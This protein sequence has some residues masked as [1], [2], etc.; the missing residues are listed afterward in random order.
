MAAPSELEALIQR[1]AAFFDRT[2]W[3]SFGVTTL[4]ALILYLVT[5][6]PDVTLG[7]AGIFCVGG[8]YAGVAH[9]P[10]YPLST[11]WAWA[12][13]K[14]APFGTIAWRVAFSSAVAGALACGVIALM[15]SR[16]GAALAKAASG[17]SLP[18]RRRDGQ[19]RAAS[20]FAAGMVFGANG[21]FWWRAV[22]QDV[23]TLSI[24]L[25]CLV[26]CLLMRWIYNPE[27]K[28]YLYAAALVYGL[29]LT[30]SQIQLAL[31]PAIPF[32]AWAGNRHVGRD[33]FLVEVL[34]F[35]AG[36]VS[37]FAGNLRVAGM[38]WGLEHPELGLFLAWGAVATGFAIALVV[39]TRRVLTE[40]KTMALCAACF[41]LG[42]VPYFY[43]PVASMT[44]PPVNW[45]YPRTVQGFYHVVNRG[46][47]ERIHPTSDT[48]QYASQ[49]RAYGAVTARQFG[50][51]YC[52]LA[53]APFLFLRRMAPKE[54][55]WPLGLL[56]AYVFLVLLSLAVLNP[57]VDRNS[58]EINQ[59]FFSASYV[60]LALWLGHGLAILGLRR[61]KSSITI[62]E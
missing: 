31:A 59:V 51:P 43:L 30:N 36:L 2:D 42:L 61:V 49:I 48:A 58:L 18:G 15:V 3:L 46:Q 22:I 29:T 12:F 8:M 27:R 26:L 40:W 44:N 56:A 38:E 25:L 11:F 37:A 1:R 21:A 34:L 14:L 55:R 19:L 60:V 41:L 7:S 17:D 50:W 5:L 53:L 35:A 16:G 24:L 28:R 23:W 32:L 13:I 45:G 62:R 39:L 4:T 33:M 47:Y 20:G 10:G 52:V 54:R 57:S 6:A 9:P